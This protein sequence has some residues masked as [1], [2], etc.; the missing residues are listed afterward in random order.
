MNFKIK[1]KE[2]ELKYTYNSFRYM[3]EFDINVF[4][5]VQHKPF[6]LLGVVSTMIYGAINNNPKVKYTLIDVEKALEE[7]IE[8]DENSLSELFEELMKAMESSNFFKKLQ[9]K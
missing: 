8:E 2:V 1:G 4:E 6:K 5:E 9:K 7:F 3:E